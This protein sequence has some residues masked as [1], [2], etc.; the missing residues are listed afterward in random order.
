MNVMSCFMF[1]R[2][3]MSCWK[4][5]FEI[6]GILCYFFMSMVIRCCLM[7]CYLFICVIITDIGGIHSKLIDFFSLL[8]SCL[9]CLYVCTMY[10]IYIMYIYI[11]AIYIIYI[12]YNTYII[13]YIIII[14]RR[15]SCLS[16]SII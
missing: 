3:Q 5:T 10:I 4:I 11:Y 1:L 12:H 9:I 8:S 2:D 7:R 15:N 14:S 16:H 6:C 13:M